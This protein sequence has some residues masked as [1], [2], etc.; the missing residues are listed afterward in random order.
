MNKYSGSSD[1]KVLRHKLFELSRLVASN[2]ANLELHRSNVEENRSLILANAIANGTAIRRFADENIEISLMEAIQTSQ[3]VELENTVK[4][5]G[6]ELITYGMLL[7]RMRQ[8]IDGNRRLLE[9]SE[10]LV[11]VNSELIAIN[12]LSSE[13]NQTL[14]LSSLPLDEFK[15]GMVEV[16]EN[17]I[18][19]ENLLKEAQ[20]LESQCS[21]LV[22]GAKANLKKIMDLNLASEKNRR[23]ITRNSEAIH[24]VNNAIVGLSEISP[25][26][27]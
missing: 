10:K 8:K 11:S 19:Q 13:L 7:T 23:N 18:D 22:F 1:Y 12:S 16:T 2:T 20:E 15:K 5:E 25:D 21:A 27:Y 9:I 24:A 26:E 17:D 3:D 14:S 6:V 4:Q